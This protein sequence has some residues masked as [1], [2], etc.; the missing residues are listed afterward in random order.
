MT[1]TPPA[2]VAATDRAARRRPWPRWA[3]LGTALAVALAGVV[4]PASGAAADSA[5]VTPGQDATVTT[6]AL[7][8]VQIDGVA[9]DQ[10]V[11]GGTVYVA[12]AFTTARPAG[13]AP[14]TSTVTRSNLLA[15]DLATG[16]LVAAW[17]PT[18]N[19]AAYAIAASP[20]G[21]RIYVG[22]D[23]TRVNGVARNRFAV[24]NR[25]TGA[26]N[27][28]FTAGANAAVRTIEASASAVYIGGN[29]NTV[30]G[31]DR[32]RVASFDATT[33]AVRSWRASVQPAQVDSIVLSADGSRLFI[34]G[35]F[36]YINNQSRLGTGAV[37]TSN[38][39]L[40]PW[41]VGDELYSYGYAA[42]MQSLATDG[43][44]V[45]GT[46]FAFLTGS[47]GSF[48]NIEGPWAADAGTSEVRWAAD[49][50][51]DTYSV[52]NDR[53]KDHIYVS[54]HPHMC[55]NIGEFPEVSPRVQRYGLAFAKAPRGEVQPNTQTGNYQS[56]EGFPAPEVRTF[57]PTF[58]SGTA[59]GQKQATWD[60]TGAGGYVLFAGEF[61]TVNGVGQQG[62]VRFAPRS[63][64]PNARGPQFS[65]STL[66][67][68]AR[69]HAAGTI[70]VA[71]PSNADPDEATLRYEVLRNDEVEPVYTVAR[72][73]RFWDRPTL[74]FSDT[75]LTPGTT[76][77]Y[78]VRAVD[79]GGNTMTSPSASAQVVTG[80]GA[81]VL[82]DYAS[83]VLADNPA[84]Y[85]RLSEGSG[86]FR[87]WTSWAD[88][89][90]GS[91]VGRGAPGALTGDT[92]GA[93]T[94]TGMG[95]SR[96]YTTRQVV[97]PHRLSVETWFR[98]T[99]TTGGVLVSFGN[100]RSTSNSS[101]H[102]RKLYMGADGRL[103]FGIYP[104]RVR[105]IT[106]IAAYNDGAWH[107]A[108]A[109]LGR[110]GMQL[111][112][113]GTSVA[114]RDD[115]T[116]GQYYNGYWRI[117]GDTIA[118]WPQA[119]EQ[120]FVGELDEVAIYHR[121]LT[122]EDVAVHRSLG[123]S[124][125]MPNLAP[126]AA[127]VA[128]GGEL[129]AQ[130]DGSGSS[131]PDGEIVSY[132]WAWGDG[133]TTT[134]TDPTA[135][136]VYEEGGTYTV[137]LTVTD[138][139]DATAS[140]ETTVEVTA[141]NA[142]PV[143]EFEAEANGLTL[144]LDAGASSDPDGS[145]DTWEW[146]L[147]DG[148][149]RTGS[150]VSHTYAASGTY[151]V[152]LTVTDDDGAQDTVTQEIEVL[153]PLD[154]VIARDAFGRTF[155]S[156]WGAADL[157]GSWTTTAGAARV[158]GSAGL[159]TVTTRGGLAGARLPGP[160]SANTDVTVTVALDKRPSGGGWTLVRGRIT[161][162]GEYRLKTSFTAGGGLSAWLVRTTAAGAETSITPVTTVSGS[163]TAG[164]VVR[165]RLAVSGT[166]P[167]T[168]RARVWTGATE[169][170]AWLLSTTDATAGLQV[171]GHVGLAGLVSSAS[172]NVPVA[173]RWD[174]L[175]VD[176]G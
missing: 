65:G 36:S 124:G 125:E 1:S 98:T 4:L 150:T 171:P 115:V 38:A 63:A 5:P 76:Y 133:T 52:W 48:S 72:P 173:F 8:T 126:T 112:V 9:W 143:A 68:T 166:S 61:P 137:T 132:A 70:Q 25:A 12:G 127:V 172:T 43:V 100:S 94:F 58:T 153:Q 47:T 44:N 140:A 103:T 88:A 33:G 142:P 108:V 175:V 6:D 77:T 10:V 80:A 83:R 81:P 162:G 176:A 74:S 40:L 110:D 154:T 135:S 120:N 144:T 22:G 145:I 56:I 26:L 28:T 109:T 113:D 136:H 60:V 57:Y 34:G 84:G 95:A 13:A 93:A 159:L 54:G 167:T 79:A 66:A 91:G 55:S 73:S 21:S 90:S 7:P 99:S 138:D 149:T 59:S 169:P 37:A 129:S 64:A 102:D 158:D 32:P 69:S 168:L 146:D 92:D 51:G 75:G 27:T 114:A 62:L 131:D 128:T 121:A 116:F 118:G 67:P 156:G 18:L 141:P 46:S 2:P 111:F 152:T 19:G 122:A 155:A 139:G 97:A 85:W 151:E 49:C 3:G 105:E 163:Y 165:M 42:G 45:Y 29:F 117:G 174:D 96:A 107:H 35:R 53:T 89:S 130:A 106:S 119:G 123:L 17:A 30:G 147:G 101:S 170:T 23:F 134:T 157:G 14:E 161:D 86:T 15:Y 78:R 160:T 164:T 41:T 104:A 50:H 31:Q 39:A 16:E 82:G 148:Q 24:L 87:D 71:W 11:V 20:D